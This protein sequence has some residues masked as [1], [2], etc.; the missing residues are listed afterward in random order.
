[1]EVI[2]NLEQGLIKEE[3][4]LVGDTTHF[5]AYSGFET[6]TYID[7]KGKEQRKSQSKTT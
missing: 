6:V 2:E 5:H 4:E 7:E 1:K 3:K